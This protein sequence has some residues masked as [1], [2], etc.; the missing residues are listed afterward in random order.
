MVNDKKY[1][2]HVI[3][4]CNNIFKVNV[5]KSISKEKYKLSLEKVELSRN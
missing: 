2:T 4:S 5:F 1:V 3:Y